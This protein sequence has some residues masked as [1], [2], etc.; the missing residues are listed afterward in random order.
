MENEKAM[1]SIGMPIYNGEKYLRQAL[2]SLVSQTYTNIELIIS[3]NASTDN[4]EKICR[5]FADKDSRI[6]Y[7]RQKGN[8]GMVNNFPFV[9]NQAR[10]KYFMW[11]AHDDWWAPSFIYTLKTVLD[12]H[13][14]YGVAMS[15]IERVQENGTHLD[16]ILFTNEND[17]TRLNRYAVLIK[18]FTK[19]F[20]IFFSYGL[21]RTDFLTKYLKRPLTRSTGSD[22]IFIAEISLATRLYSIPE[23]LHKRTEIYKEF[24]GTIGLNEKWASDYVK[25]ML[26]RLL[27][28][29]IIP[30]R[31]KVLVPFFWIVLLWSNKYALLKEFF[32]KIFMIGKNFKN[33]LKQFKN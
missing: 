14:E 18:L 22:K 17:L 7:I 33:R 32:P 9:F 21:F 30:L 31:R 5:E 4:T 10:G 19:K 15:S 28:S 20:P 26:R 29:P 8:I 11:A 3:D 25:E 23:I 27:S 24:K 6:Q 12:E 16:E 2:S 13:P 1:V